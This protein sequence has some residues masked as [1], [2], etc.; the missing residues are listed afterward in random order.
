MQRKM[1][2][3]YK[4]VKCGYEWVQARPTHVMCPICN[5]LYVEWINF[6]EMREYWKGTVEGYKN[7][8]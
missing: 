7:Y 3:K 6:D 1:R 4:C 5:S 8:S 2:A